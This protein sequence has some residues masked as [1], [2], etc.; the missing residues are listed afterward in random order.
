MGYLI[1]MLRPLAVIT[2][3][4]LSSAACGGD[5]DGGSGDRPFT[6]GELLGSWE[7]TSAISRVSIEAEGQSLD[8]LTTTI[9]SSSVAYDFREDGT[10]A[11]VGFA[12]VFVD[13]APEFEFLI[14][15]TSAVETFEAA[16]AYFVDDETVAFVETFDGVT[17][18]VVYDVVAFAA[19]ERLELEAVVE[20][21]TPGAD[22]DSEVDDFNTR[23]RVTRVFEQ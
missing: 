14:P 17:D 9:D 21:L 19:D 22:P 12:R 1:P 7:L 18:T 2:A 5:D 10:Y 13:V 23:V 3:I 8:F 16:G 6:R 15:D 20:E 11:S 4:A